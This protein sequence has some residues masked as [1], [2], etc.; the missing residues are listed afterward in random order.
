MKEEEIAKMATLEGKLKLM[1][2]KLNE[3]KKIYLT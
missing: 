3:E 1:C 2:E